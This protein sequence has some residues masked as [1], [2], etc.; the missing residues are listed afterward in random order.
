ML[1]VHL[2]QFLSIK[3]IVRCVLKCEKSTDIF[4]CQSLLLST[5]VYLMMHKPFVYLISEI[6]PLFFLSGSERTPLSTH[7]NSCML[8][9]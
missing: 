8:S 3:L 1:E 6:N 9:V 5:L 4:S 7:D 2:S